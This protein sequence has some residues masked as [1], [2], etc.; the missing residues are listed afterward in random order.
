[1]QDGGRGPPSAQPNNFT[2]LDSTAGIIVTPS[3]RRLDNC[4][5]VTPIAPIR[6]IR[7]AFSSRGRYPRLGRNIGPESPNSRPT[8]RRRSGIDSEESFVASYIG[9]TE[10]TPGYLATHVHQFGHNETLLDQ[11]SIES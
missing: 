5:G 9:K 10:Q 8:P 1:M 7:V 3:Q 4:F 11:G 2:P 6:A